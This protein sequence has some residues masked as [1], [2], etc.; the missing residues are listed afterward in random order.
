M[1]ERIKTYK[2]LRVFQNAMDSAM[3]IFYITKDFPPE[4][5]YSM[6]D[7][8]RRSSR[9]VETQVWII[10]SQLV[11]IIPCHCPL[12]SLRG[13]ERRGNLVA[14]IEIASLHSQ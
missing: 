11:R 4:E 8:M 3:K 14:L 1:G 10:T 13:A 7:Q 9:S 5:R 2:E 6:V 12:L